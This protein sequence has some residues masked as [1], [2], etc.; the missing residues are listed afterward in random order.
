MS[1]FFIKQ[2]KL[3]EDTRYIIKFDNEQGVGFTFKKGTLASK[4]KKYMRYQ[5]NL[6]G[7]TP[8]ELYFVGALNFPEFLTKEEQNISSMYT[9]LEES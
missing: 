4:V 6:L 3:L 8:L 2:K 7:Y 1:K 5:A 9:L